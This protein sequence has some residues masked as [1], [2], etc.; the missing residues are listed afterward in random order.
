M[1]KVFIVTSGSYS[2]YGIDAVFSSEELAKKFIESFA[3]SGYMSMDIEEWELNP[4]DEDLKRGR[5][6]YMLRINK[7]GHAYDIELEDSTYG[8]DC[9]NRNQKKP[10]YDNKKSLVLHVFADDENHAIKIANEKRVKILEAD[11]WGKQ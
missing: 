3:V 8:F 7:E 9:Q 6:P 5:K 4:F 11:A 2:D 10:F 1:G